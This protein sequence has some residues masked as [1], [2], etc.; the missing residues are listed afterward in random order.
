MGPPCL[1]G[2]RRSA[3][4]QV[5]LSR[6]IK[7]NTVSRKPTQ[8]PLGISQPESSLQV[9]CPWDSPGKNTGVG[10]HA[11]LQGIFPTQGWSPGLVCLLHWQ[12]GSLPLAP[13]GKP[14]QVVLTSGRGS[15]CQCRRREVK[16]CR[17][18]HWVRNM[19]STRK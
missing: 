10:C 6:C 4:G 3:E 12:A 1:R 15:A 9:L 14:F 11:L 2:E 19:P 18:D 7:A 13:L 5:R 8:T 16:R 17:F